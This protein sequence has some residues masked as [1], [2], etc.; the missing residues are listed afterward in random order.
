[1]VRVPIAGEL[2]LSRRALGSNL[3]FPRKLANVFAIVGVSGNEAQM[4]DPFQ[5]RRWYLRCVA[6]ALGEC[7]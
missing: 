6:S 7:R 5:P 4:F 2:R 1:M 3:N